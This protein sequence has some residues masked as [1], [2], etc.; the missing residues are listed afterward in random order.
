M[1][2][3]E[4]EGNQSREVLNEALLKKSWEIV[5][6]KIIEELLPSSG[7]KFYIYEAYID[8]TKMT[9]ETKITY[10]NIRRAW[11]RTFAYELNREQIIN[12]LLGYWNKDFDKNWYAIRIECFPNQFN[13]TDAIN[14]KQVTTIFDGTI[15]EL[16]EYD[17]S[18]EILDSARGVINAYQRDQDIQQRIALNQA[19]NIVATYLDQFGPESRAS[20][21]R[22][23][24]TY[25][26]DPKLIRNN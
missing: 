11:G 5:F 1:S 3:L 4:G 20:G 7:K 9:E 26:P 25:Q 16:F 19:T 14:L 2:N 8:K 24:A 18:R 10:G 22:P 17:K 6:R 21:L 13:R 15:P 12:M 23:A